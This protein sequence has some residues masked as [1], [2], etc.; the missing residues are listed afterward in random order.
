MEFAIILVAERS[1][2]LMAVGL[3]VAV[4]RQIVCIDSGVCRVEHDSGG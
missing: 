2:L 4:A 3:V 1:G